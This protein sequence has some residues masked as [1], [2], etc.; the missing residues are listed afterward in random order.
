MAR[1]DDLIAEQREELQART[2][3]LVEALGHILPD[4]TA[5][6]PGDEAAFD[7]IATIAALTFYGLT[8][9]P[10]VEMH[11]LDGLWLE[12]GQLIGHVIY[13]DCT[14]QAQEAE[15]EKLQ[16]EEPYANVIDIRTRMVKN[17]GGKQ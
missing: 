16:S 15:A 14:R 9:G 13:D 2:L 5:D 12:Y 17:P 3:K 11:E 8:I 6:D 4:V 10:F 1:L 7:A